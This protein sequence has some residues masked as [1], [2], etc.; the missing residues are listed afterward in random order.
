MKNYWCSSKRKIPQVK[1]TE[2]NPFK[3]FSPFFHNC[4]DASQSQRNR[5]LRAINTY[6]LY[7]IKEELKSETDK[8]G[9][10]DVFSWLTW[11]NVN[12][13]FRMKALR[14]SRF[15]CVSVLWLSLSPWPLWAPIK[16]CPINQWWTCS[17]PVLL[18]ILCWIKVRPRSCW[19]TDPWREIEWRDETEIYSAGQ[20]QQ[21]LNALW[22]THYMSLTLKQ[23]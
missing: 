8:D 20:F 1:G 14:I 4:V 21:I 9:W 10:V 2:E 11:K 23:H 15:V 5:N 19:Q 3:S 18:L 17:R 13:Q 12:L 7:P 22:R 16:C 6:S